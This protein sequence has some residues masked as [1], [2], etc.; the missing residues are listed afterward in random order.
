MLNELKKEQKI[1]G[2][3]K[4]QIVS[5]L[6]VANFIKNQNL[7]PYQVLLLATTSKIDYI[8][9]EN[10]KRTVSLSFVPCYTTDYFYDFTLDKPEYSDNFWRVS[11][12]QASLNFTTEEWDAWYRLKC[13]PS[14]E[15]MLEFIK[16]LIDDETA[17][18]EYFLFSD[19]S[20]LLLK[21]KDLTTNCYWLAHEEKLDTIKDLEEKLSSHYYFREDIEQALGVELP[22]TI[23]TPLPDVNVANTNIDDTC[24]KEIATLTSRIAELEKVNLELKE[25][26]NEANK[27]LAPKSKKSYLNIIKALKDT[28]CDKEKG[29]FKNQSE[30]ETYLSDLYR[31][32]IGFSESN[33]NNVFADA[34]QLK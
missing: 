13:K 30:L 4:D 31:G 11:D 9:I 16:L 27:V 14:K 5:V 7:P 20:E 33:L 6:D 25:Q 19:V 32:Y 28:L 23:T 1:R 15:N 22:D 18:N 21:L 3:F 10:L 17:P 24:T 26:L 29:L 34:N 8:S 12:Y 2:Y